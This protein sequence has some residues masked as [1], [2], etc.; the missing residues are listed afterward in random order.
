MRTASQ[1]KTLKSV[2]NKAGTSKKNIS[3]GVRK[4]KALLIRV[5]KKSYWNIF[6]EKNNWFSLKWVK[7]FNLGII[8]SF[9]INTLLVP[10][11]RL[12]F[13]LAFVEFRSLK[14]AFE[15][16]NKILPVNAIYII[17]RELAKVFYVSL[18]KILKLI[19]ST[20]LKLEIS[21]IL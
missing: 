11:G 15:Q 18:V 1:I 14:D 20:I 6:D 19:F 10:E 13:L 12:V 8:N 3:K 16:L 21:Y 9:Y 4:E 2:R 5:L 7:I 17:G